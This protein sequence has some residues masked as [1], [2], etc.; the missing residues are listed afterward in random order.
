[1]R[2][3]ATICPVAHFQLLAPMQPFDSHTSDTELVSA[4][5]AGNN[6]AFVALVERYQQPLKVAARSRLGREDW[7]DDVVQE[8]FLCLL[9]WLRSYDSRFSFRT[10]LWTVLLNQCTR[11]AQKQARQAAGTLD[12]YDTSGDAV[13]SAGFLA[14]GETSPIEALLDSERRGQLHALLS[15]LP[16]AQ[17]D[18]LRL[19]FFA[20]LKFQEIAAAMDCSLTTAKARVKQGLLQLS[21][22]LKV[23]SEDR[24]GA[25]VDSRGDA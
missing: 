11:H 1:M 12:G 7:A 5:L 8:T 25:F 18:A 9:K 13:S 14:S 15:R 16:Q 17:A 10:W 2:S 20:G 3:R 24:Q 22:W 4:I 6:Q 23:G 21:E 19:R